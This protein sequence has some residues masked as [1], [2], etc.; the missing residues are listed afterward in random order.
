[1]LWCGREAS[2]KGV[3]CLAAHGVLK[4]AGSTG[5]NPQEDPRD[6]S[7]MYMESGETG[8]PP[9]LKILHRR[10]DC[11]G[12]V[13]WKRLI[14]CASL[15]QTKLKPRAVTSIRRP[16]VLPGGPGLY[17]PRGSRMAKYRRS[18]ERSVRAN[19]CADKRRSLLPQ[20]CLHEQASSYLL[21]EVLHSVR[22]H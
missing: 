12:I 20:A 18:I 16:S 7:T 11:H 6:G 4:S 14:I 22:L 15:L 13:D 1:M 17:F 19:F 3:A 21:A 9:F 2:P 10:S 8:A 5:A